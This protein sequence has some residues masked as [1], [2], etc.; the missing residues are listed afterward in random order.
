MVFGVPLLSTSTLVYFH[1]FQL[2]VFVVVHGV[3]M[4]SRCN[5]LLKIYRSGLKIGE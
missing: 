1:F 4:T 5:S 2:H 3:P